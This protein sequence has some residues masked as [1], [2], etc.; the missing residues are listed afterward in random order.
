MAFVGVCGKCGAITWWDK[1]DAPPCQFCTETQQ[2]KLKQAGPP[3]PQVQNITTPRVVG[4]RP[5]T[6]VA[7]Q[8]CGI[9]IGLTLM[10]LRSKE[11]CVKCQ[12]CHWY[13]IV[14]FQRLLVGV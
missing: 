5:V 14:N 9:S 3:K 11:A 10:D 1:G 13:K 8:K 6:S 4:E 12:R 2:E 7:C